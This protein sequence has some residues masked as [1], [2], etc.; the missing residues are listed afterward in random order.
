MLIANSQLLI[1]FTGECAVFCTILR[2]VN[3]TISIAIHK[4]MLSVCQVT[5]YDI[6]LYILSLYQQF[7]HTVDIVESLIR[8]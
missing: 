3:V 4:L 6:Y 8:F 2:L 1:Y 5:K 7:I